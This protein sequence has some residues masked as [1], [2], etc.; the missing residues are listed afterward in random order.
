MALALSLPNLSELFTFYT[1]EEE[2]IALG[3][4]GQVQRPNTQ[5]V[6]YLSIKTVRYYSQGF[7]SLKALAAAA[8]L[9][10]ESQKHI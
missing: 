8:L 1:T 7:V 2:G 6:S 9:T 4:L 3:L 5:I 10:L